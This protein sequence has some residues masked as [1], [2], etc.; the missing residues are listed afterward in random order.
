M[1]EERQRW[2]KIDCE[3]SFFEDQWK[4][5]S[6]SKEMRFIF[7]RQKVKTQVKGPVQL[8]LFI[9][10]ESSSDFRVVVTNKTKSAKRVLVFHH[11]RG[12]QEKLFGELKDTSNMDY[13]LVNRLAWNQV[14]LMAV[15]MAHNLNREPQMRS[16][17]KDRGTTSKR[18]THWVFESMN[19][20][21]LKI[22]K[23]AGRLTKPQGLLTLTMSVNATVQSA[24]DHYLTQLGVVS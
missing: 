8:D 7:V 18:A 24:I 2:R 23:Q 14:F 10:F 19:S 12:S 3:W 21:R 20:I 6:W 9:P 15:I 1:I 16:N 22:I 13:I 5:K 17:N 4:P 11:G